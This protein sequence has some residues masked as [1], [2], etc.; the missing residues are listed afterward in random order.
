MEKALFRD[1]QQLLNSQGK[2]GLT[3]VLLSR[4]VVLADT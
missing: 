1:Q 3:D 2:R 4:G